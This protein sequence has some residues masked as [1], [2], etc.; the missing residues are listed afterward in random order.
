M[1]NNLDH[2]VTLGKELWILVQIAFGLRYPWLKVPDP[3]AV[4]RT[5]EIDQNHWQIQ[6]KELQRGNNCISPE[7]FPLNLHPLFILESSDKLRSIHNLRYLNGY[8]P[9]FLY[10]QENIDDFIHNLEPGDLLWFEDMKSCFQQFTLCPN[11]R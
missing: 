9:T 11:D 1:R 6:E 8:V 7:D 3:I 4:G 5:P 2:H 10:Q